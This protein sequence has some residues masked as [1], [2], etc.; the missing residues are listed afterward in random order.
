MMYIAMAGSLTANVIMLVLA[1]VIVGAVYLFYEA[2]ERLLDGI[3]ESISKNFGGADAV[4]NDIEFRRLDSHFRAV[5]IPMAQMLEIRDYRETEKLGA[6]VIA[7]QEQAAAGGTASGV[8]TTPGVPQQPG[9][10]ASTQSRQQPAAPA[11][12]ASAQSRQPAAPAAEPAYAELPCPS[13]GTMNNARARF[14][15]AC[16][17][18]MQPDQPPADPP[19]EQ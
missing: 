10:P 15:K 2:L 4:V 8:P 19:A 7:A 12:P 18:R 11:A 16:G 17:G 9:A 1:V 3:I 6:S 14:C 13:C 5:V